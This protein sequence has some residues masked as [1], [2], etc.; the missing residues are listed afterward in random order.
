[1]DPA[2]NEENTR[3]ARSRALSGSRTL[4]T[5]PELKSKSSQRLEGYAANPPTVEL[6]AAHASLDAC[7][8][9]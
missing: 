3:L 1:M 8:D 7:N 2:E 6:G 4:V 5:S 9:Q